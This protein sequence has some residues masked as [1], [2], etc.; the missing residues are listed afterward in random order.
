M[1]TLK[2]T[3]F[4][5]PVTA[6]IAIPGSKSYTNRALLLAAL[7]KGTV[8]IN[9][10]LVSDDTHAMIAC[11]RELG[12]R[13]TFKDD[14]LAPEDIARQPGS[15]I[16]TSDISAIQEGEYHQNA[17][18]SGTAIRFVL[19][20]SAIIPG[21]K[22]IRGEGRLNERPIA[23]L[24]EVLEQLGARIEYVD[25]HGYPPVKVLS[26]RLKPGTV[27][28]KGT[29]SSQF[30]SAL[31]MIAPIV[32]E[33]HIEIEGE[34]ISKPYIDMTIDAMRSFSVSVE[35]DGYKRY[36]VPSGQAYHA[37]EYTVEGDFS[38]AAY[39]FAIAALT[40][41]TLTLTNLNPKTYQA[42]AG[43]LKILENM[44]NDVTYGERSI[45]ITGKCVKAVSVDMQDC[46]DQAQ[47]LAVLAAFAE[48]TTTI[49]GVQSLR[50]KET[51]RVV[52][53]ETELGKMG[54]HA[55]ST[56][57]TLI[58]HGGNP[59]PAKI[60][61]YGDHRMAMAFAVAA[62]KLPGMEIMEPDVVTKTFPRFWKSLALAGAPFSISYDRPN[63]ILIGMRG[64]GKTTVGRVLAQKL[65]KELID[66]DELLEEREGMKIAETVEKR[67]WEYFRD[68]ESEI[69]AEVG[70][71]K[72]TIIS[73]G[74]G[75]IERPEN[76][77]ALKDNGVLVLLNAPA[78][79]L[80]ERL[81]HDPG[82]PALTNAASAREEIETV[83]AE[84]KK[85]YEAAADE[86]IMDTNLTLEQKTAEVLKRLERRGIV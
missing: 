57:D 34:Q 36:A 12:I 14:M 39:F 2:L 54:I 85:L 35:N 24:V 15:L 7:T 27:R 64:G 78:D 50:V 8:V 30:L 9:N 70:K 28:I 63:I 32:G 53:L 33:L 61:T 20:L 69:V 44:G 47:T 55:E 67:G 75:V 6:T 77:A 22:T 51:E 13:C 60:D 29:V 83:L 19:A 74:G 59:K 49:K 23:H 62:A 79:I 5:K 11:L 58:V 10:P 31:L 21:I 18:Y 43:F 72:D 1:K 26:S 82:R 37:T 16:V 86:I 84:R 65:N 68:R 41:S 66:I 52:A 80:A 17:N 25:K 45:T 42:D 73:T 46:P 3:P 76:V 40:R 71:R 56:Q 38:S 4:S 48:G 81:A